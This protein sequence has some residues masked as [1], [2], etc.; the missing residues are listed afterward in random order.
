MFSVIG[1]HAEEL[2]AEWGGDKLVALK[3]NR[4][5]VMAFN[6]APVIVAKSSGLGSQ[7]QGWTF[8]VDEAAAADFWRKAALK[9]IATVCPPVMCLPVALPCCG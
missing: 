5:V 9:V 4:H 7:V 1:P 2:V 8:I 6:G 3:E